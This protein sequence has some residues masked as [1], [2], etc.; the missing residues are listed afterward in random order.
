MVVVVRMMIVT[1]SVVMLVSMMV[2]V[3]VIMMPVRVMVIVV[4][5]MLRHHRIHQ[6]K[7]GNNAHI[8]PAQRC[9]NGFNPHIAMTAHVNEQVSAVYGDNVSGRGLKAVAFRSGRKQ[10]RKGYPVPGNLADK[11]EL[12]KNGGDNPQPVFIRIRAGRAASGKE[13]GKSQAQ[14]NDNDLSHKNVLLKLRVIKM[15]AADNSS[16]PSV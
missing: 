4:M 3:P 5:D 11:I 13:Q 15:L 1:V 14:K 12:R 6:I 9:Q 7:E 2:S 10:H 16:A 8:F